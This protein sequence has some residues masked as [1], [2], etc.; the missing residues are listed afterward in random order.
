M[1]TTSLLAPSFHTRHAL[2]SGTLHGESFCRFRSRCERH[3]SA[4]GLRGQIARRKAPSGSSSAYSA[5]GAYS[6]PATSAAS[7]A[8]AHEGS[9]AQL[10]GFSVKSL[11]ACAVGALSSASAAGAESAT[12]DAA[13]VATIADASPADHALGSPPRQT[14]ASPE[15]A[16]SATTYPRHRTGRGVPRDALRASPARPTQRRATRGSLT[17]ARRARA[18][19]VAIA[20]APA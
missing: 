11:R 20:P 15:R 18:Q 12:A 5:G 3:M 13:A 7:R 9:P 19:T 1:S 8:D 4:V 16:S 14:P 17:P 6:P 10:S 2:S